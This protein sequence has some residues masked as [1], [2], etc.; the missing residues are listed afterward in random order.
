M[1]KTNSENTKTLK[2]N[3]TKNTQNHNKRNILLIILLI[4]VTILI[5]I[6][7]RKGI[8]LNSLSNKFQDA[9]NQNNYSIEM[10]LYQKEDTVKVKLLHKDNLVLANLKDK[11]KEITETKNNMNNTDIY[12]NNNGNMYSKLNSEGSM[13]NLTMP[14]I[15]EI[16]NIKDLLVN[17]L[18]TS[19]NETKCNGKDCYYIKNFRSTVLPSDKEPAGIYIEKSTGLPVRILGGSISSSTDSTNTIIDFYYSFNN[20]SDS[21]FKIPNI[22]QYKMQE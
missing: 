4:V 6:T 1:K 10:Y 16:G 7:I 8:L 11:D 19:I 3:T 5:I 13:I 14:N 18:V 2:E 22:E 15:L 21:D 17:S 12:I 9:Q 20:V